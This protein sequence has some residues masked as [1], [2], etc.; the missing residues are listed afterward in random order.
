MNIA[1]IGAGFTGLSAGYYLSKAG[2]DV[3]IFEVGD[4]PGGLA[5]GF[6][7][8]KWK[9]SLEAHYHHLFLSDNVILDLAK[10]VGQEI[11]FERPITSSLVEK[12]IYQLDS[13]ASLLKFPKLPVID[14]IRTGLVLFYLK[15]TTSWEPLEKYKAEKFLKALMGKRSWKVLWEPLFVSKFG[16][17]STEIPLSWFWARIKKRSAKLGY[18]VGGFQTFVE[19][20]E[21][22]IRKNRGKINYNS[23]VESIE[24]KDKRL[25]LTVNG[26][27][28]TFDRVIC[29]LPTGEFAKVTKG[30]P[31]NYVKKL[32]QLT[33]IGAI[34]MILSLKSKFFEDGS[35][36]LSINDK[37][38]YVAV[39]EHTNFI[40]KRNYNNENLLYIGS[41]MPPNHEYFGKSKEQLLKIYLPYLKKINPRINKLLINKFWLFRDKFAQPIVTLNYSKSIP[42]MK[43]PIEGLYLANMQ[44][45]YPW[46]RGTNYAVELGKKV[47]D[48]MIK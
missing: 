41:Y 28:E 43:T 5:S 13:A 46:D 3:T 18:P 20:I 38:P 31:S 33:G 25:Y 9:W 17:Y 2:V 19:A 36:W 32:N 4:K 47:A 37:M 44:Q 16:K 40:D 45:V 24:R 21:K 26:S 42:K 35:Y 22:E 30:L 29:T 7:E 10:E 11:V 14:R 1:I 12:K 39:V 48:L 15:Y 23:L 6:T 34:N 27:R 8:K